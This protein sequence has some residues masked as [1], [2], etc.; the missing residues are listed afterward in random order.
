[1]GQVF[2]MTNKVKRIVFGHKISHF[3]LVNNMGEKR[4][5]KRAFKPSFDDPQSSVDR[6]SSSQ[7]LK[8]IA[9]TRATRVYQKGGIS[10]KIQMRRFRGNQS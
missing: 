2:K 3:M 5:K 10:P 4:E 8:F 1:M 9:S 6:N 7:E